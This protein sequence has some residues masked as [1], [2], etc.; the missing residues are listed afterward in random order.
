MRKLIFLLP[1]WL[2]FFLLVSCD[3]SSP[4]ENEITQ[5]KTTAIPYEVNQKGFD[6]LNIIIQKK[7]GKDIC[8]IMDDWWNE[9]HK[10]N[11]FIKDKYNNTWPPESLD[12]Q[13]KLDEVSSEKIRNKYKL[14]KD[15][16][17]NMSIV[18]IDICMPK[19]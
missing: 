5:Y 3:N 1:F 10:N 6:S 11:V 12:E 4:Q 13:T 17:Y 9:I 8:Y 18:C 19:Y 14:T 2:Y 7:T 15:D 16:L